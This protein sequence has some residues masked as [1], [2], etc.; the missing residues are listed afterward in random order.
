MADR[1]PTANLATPTAS[2]A[3]LFQ[4]CASKHGTAENFSTQKPTSGW[5]SPF[6]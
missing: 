2:L 4:E 1:G 3:L 5:R 6:P